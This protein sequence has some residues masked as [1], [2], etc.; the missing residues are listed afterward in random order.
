[1]F[2][3][4]RRKWHGSVM[5]K[6]S[7]MC[8]W[9]FPLPEYPKTIFCSGHRKISLSYRISAKFLVSYFSLFTLVNRRWQYKSFDTENLRIINWTIV[10]D[11]NNSTNKMQQFH[12][13]ITGWSVVGRGLAD[14]DQQRCCR[15]HVP[16][17]IQVDGILV[18]TNVCNF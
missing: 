10:S 12:K 8:S 15:R 3:V 2:H 9:H 6:V 1:M 17:S 11:L 7:S 13:F 18:P 4:S 16:L 5:M 14:H